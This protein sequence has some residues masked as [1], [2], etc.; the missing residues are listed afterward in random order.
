ME[1]W[2]DSNEAAATV[3]K[4]QEECF[5]DPDLAPAMKKVNQLIVYD[6]SESGPGCKVWVDCRNNQLSA[7]IGDPQGKPDLVMSL[8]ADDA[9]R[10]WSN[11]LNPI[12][13][14][15][16]RKIRVKGS[17]TGLLK[18]APKLKKTAELYNGVLTQLGMADRI[19][20]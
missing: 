1:F 12:V 2:K 9:H 8:S 5:K 19:L 18:L 4:L 7:G 17:A 15:T 11:K 6:Y 13:A 10:A 16:R 20:K 14:I 3:L